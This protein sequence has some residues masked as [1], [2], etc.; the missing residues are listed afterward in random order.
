MFVSVIETGSFVGVTRT[1][2]VFIRS[3]T[4]L[5]SSSIVIISLGTGHGCN[6]P[7]ICASQS[8][9]FR[10]LLTGQF[11][12]SL[13]TRHNCDDG[14]PITTIRDCQ[15]GLHVVI[16]MRLSAIEGCTLSHLWN[17]AAS[18]MEDMKQAVCGTRRQCSSVSW[19]V[20]E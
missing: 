7:D 9:Y 6:A 19:M 4:S 20:R 10:A 18:A 16:V 13:T 11:A 12:K 15:P 2:V 8:D 14:L 3:T 5:S 17:I 1:S